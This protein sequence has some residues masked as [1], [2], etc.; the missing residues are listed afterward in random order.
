FADPND[1]VLSRL[2][3]KTFDGSGN[4][5]SAVG[6]NLE[7][8]ALAS[9]LGVVLAPH[10]LTPAD[11]LGFGGFQLTVDYAST[12]IDSSAPYWRAL[13][14]SP[15]P[16]GTGSA[17]HGPDMMQTV[18]LFVRKG[19]WFPSLEIGAGG[20]HLVDSHIWTGQ[21]YTKV[22]LHE[23]YHQLPIPSV[24]VRGAVSRMMT[25]RELDLTVASLDITISKHFGI[26]GTWKFH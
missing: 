11:T 20:I 6:Q 12:T 2:S 3:T 19:L 16:E 24:A 26:G 4:L 5:V 14:G 10:L 22:A 13:N 25:Q 7:L 17:P 23:G 1:L 21:L 8:R 15:D 9:Q 18:G